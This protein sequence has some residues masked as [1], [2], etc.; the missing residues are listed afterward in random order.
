MLY[1]SVYFNIL[2][3]VAVTCP[4]D[5][6]HIEGVATSTHC[7]SEETGVVCGHAVLYLSL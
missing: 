1:T 7:V 2:T 3:N 5:G 6:I 4:A